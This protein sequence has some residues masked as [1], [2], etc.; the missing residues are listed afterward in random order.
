MVRVNSRVD[1]GD[2]RALP[3]GPERL[4]DLRRAHHLDAVGG[5]GVGRSGRDVLGSRRAVD[6]RSRSPANHRRRESSLLPSRVRLRSS[7]GRP[8]RPASTNEPIQ[9]DAVGVD[10]DE[11]RVREPEASFDRDR[12][13]SLS[14]RFEVG[15]RARGVRFEVVRRERRRPLRIPPSPS[16]VPIRVPRANRTT[17]LTVVPF[18]ERRSEAITSPSAV[19]TEP[20][21]A[22]SVLPEST[23]SVLLVT[24]PP[25]T[26]PG[27]TAATIRQATRTSVAAVAVEKGDEGSLPIT[28]A[29]PP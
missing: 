18:A 22:G 27:A 25:A 5:V 28:S 26:A 23:A 29:R 9:R 24:K 4:P 8:R 19:E 11:H 20:T 13:P 16:S 1:H 6:R 12:G 3:A 17:S 2:G 14:E 15:L 10:R 21:A 7:R